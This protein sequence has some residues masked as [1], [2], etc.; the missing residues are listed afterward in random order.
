M[1]AGT[2]IIREHI[3]S[4]LVHSAIRVE[5]HETPA[6]Q[7]SLMRDDRINVAAIVPI[8][9]NRVNAIGTLRQQRRIGRAVLETRPSRIQ[10]SN[11]I[12]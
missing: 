2:K 11:A 4:R 7:R 9:V 12:E 1:A 10:S 3:A 8:R 5:I 6:S